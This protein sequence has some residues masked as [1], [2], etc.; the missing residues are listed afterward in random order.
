M[1]LYYQCECGNKIN[2]LTLELA[3]SKEEAL[4]IALY[5][6]GVSLWQC[7]KCGTRYRIKKIPIKIVNIA[8]LVWFVVSIILK[9][10]L[11]IDVNLLGF[12]VKL[13]FIGIVIVVVFEIFFN[14][15]EKITG[16]NATSEA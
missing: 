7:Y 5:D 1:S 6:M 15:F 12:F 9:I 4:D 14:H 3:N 8:I 10:T 11:R 13:I 16:E 2:K